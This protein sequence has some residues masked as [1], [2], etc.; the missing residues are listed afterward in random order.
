[1]LR[2]P[3]FVTLLSTF[4]L[5]TLLAGSGY[6]EEDS[7]DSS[8]LRETDA[9]RA[10]RLSGRIGLTGFQ[11]M[12]DARTPATVSLRAGIRYDLGV[13]SLD[14]NGAQKAVRDKQVHD[15][16]VYAGGSLLGLVDVAASIPWSYR[17]DDTDLRGARDFVERDR[18]WADFDFAAKVSLDVWGPLTLAPYLHGSFPTGEPQ[19]RDL[20]EF[21]GG[22]AATLSLFNHYLAVHGNAG[23][24]LQEEGLSA[25]RFRAGVSAV[26]WS[27]PGLLLRVYA[28]GDGIEYEGRPSTDIDLEFG[29]QTILFGFIS[30]EAGAS[31]RLLDAGYLSKTTKRSLR[32]ANVFD[33]H[34]D[35][36]GTWNLHFAAGVV[37]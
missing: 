10:L 29:V 36:D 12:V 3:R 24:F 23:G 27:D 32:N 5:S 2:S 1:M 19:V 33:R 22:V 13:R 6:A 14:F 37:F 4:A 8:G 9:A 7:G 34:F 28:Y 25:L 17:V 21:E 16:S 31:V 18:G 26:V 15:F 30:L 11:D 20:L 35:D